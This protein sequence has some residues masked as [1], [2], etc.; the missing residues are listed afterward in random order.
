[1]KLLPLEDYFSSVHAQ[2]GQLSDP[3]EFLLY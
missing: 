2:V 3:L 1:M